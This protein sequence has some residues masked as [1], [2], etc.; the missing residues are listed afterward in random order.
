MWIQVGGYDHLNPA[1][2]TVPIEPL[3]D[4]ILGSNYGLLR[5]LHH[6][7]KRGEQ[8]GASELRQRQARELREFLEETSFF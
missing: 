7:I 3:F 2:V 6:V 5:F 8:P 4:A 1:G